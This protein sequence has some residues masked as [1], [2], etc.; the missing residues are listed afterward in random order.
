[1]ITTEILHGL[2]V[3]PDAASATLTV[4]RSGGERFEATLRAVAAPAYVAAIPDIWSPPDP[5]A[6]A[7]RSGCAI[8]TARSGR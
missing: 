5:P 2:G 8:A 4:E 7:R 6:C 3:T 1:M